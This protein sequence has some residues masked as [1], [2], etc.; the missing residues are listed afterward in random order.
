MGPDEEM[1]EGLLDL[2][3]LGKDAVFTHSGG[4]PVDCKVFINFNVLL[5]PAGIEAQAWQ[6]GTTIDALLSDASGIGI[7]AS[8]PSRDDTF[9]IAGVTYTVKSILEND[10]FSVKAVVT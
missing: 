2:Y 1:K 8:E 6:R 5:Q 7:G 3:A 10:G 9:T 4:D